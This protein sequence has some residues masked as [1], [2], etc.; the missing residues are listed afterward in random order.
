MKEVKKLKISY[1]LPN[2][3][4]NKKVVIYVTEQESEELKK[5][6]NESHQSVASLLRRLTK[7]I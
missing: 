4:R 7:S 1:K 5:K 2:E 3:L 6:A